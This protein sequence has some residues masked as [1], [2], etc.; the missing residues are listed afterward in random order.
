MQVMFDDFNPTTP[1]LSIINS[2]Q[3]WVNLGSIDP[4]LI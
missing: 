3:S 4:T 2:V 1:N